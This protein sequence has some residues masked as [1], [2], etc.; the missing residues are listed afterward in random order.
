MGVNS[1][2]P[3]PR[4]LPPSPG[5]V[6]L[7]VGAGPISNKAIALEEQGSVSRSPTAFPSQFNVYINHLRSLL[8]HRF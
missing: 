7:L 3:Q 5:E 6:I 2:I 8:K 1:S 4:F